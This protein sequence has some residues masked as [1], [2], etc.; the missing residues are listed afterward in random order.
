MGAA[1]DAPR[2]RRAA[3]E[4]MARP[5]MGGIWLMQVDAAIAGYLCI[6]LCFSLEFDGCFALLDELYV[7]PAF[8]GGGLGSVAIAFA[9]DWSRSRGLAA[10]R[11]EVARGNPRAIDLYRKSGFK[12]H[13]RLLMTKWL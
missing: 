1:H 9:E 12:A 4:L 6:T 5:E 3:T 2:A 8:R 10:M 7:E 11:L 13:D